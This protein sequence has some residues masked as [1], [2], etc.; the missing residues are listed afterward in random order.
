MSYM[1]LLSIVGS[2]DFFFRK[3]F[4]MTYASILSA[5]KG[6]SNCSISILSSFG[7]AIFPRPPERELPAS[8]VW[9]Y[10]YSR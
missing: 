8:D 4:S 10:E 9:Y 6:N 7:R 2:S 5:G 1:A 3:L